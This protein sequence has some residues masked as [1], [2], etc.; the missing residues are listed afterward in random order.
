MLNSPSKKLAMICM[1]ALLSAC[2]SLP[3]E[4]TTKTVE[5][6]EPQAEPG[7]QTEK[8]E[9]QQ[10][11]AAENLHELALWSAKAQ[12]TD[13]AIKQFQQLVKLDP[14]FPMANTN[15]GLLLIKKGKFEQARTALLNAIQQDKSDAIAYNHLAIAERQLGNFNKAK[16][17]YNKA[18]DEQPGYANAHLNLGILLDIYLQELPAALEQYKLYQELTNRQDETIEKWVIDLQRRIDSGDKSKG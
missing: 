13:D 3:P 7:S 11:T 14:A 15:L 8:V 16:E 17:Y 12:K 2:Q 9:A 1:L 5:T 10:K 6:T 18:I 4:N